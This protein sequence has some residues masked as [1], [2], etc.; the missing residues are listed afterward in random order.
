M[1][2]SRGPARHRRG[3]LAR[4]LRLVVVAGIAAL[5]LAAPVPGAAAPAAPPA[6]DPL[7]LTSQ[8][9]WIGPGQTFD[10]QL[11]TGTGAPPVADRGLAVA[12]YPC[13]HTRSDFDETVTATSLP[14]SPEAETSAP[15]RWTSLPVTGTQGADLRVAVTVDGPS[16]GTAPPPPGTSFAA[17]LSCHVADGG[18]FPV[19]IS[20][21]DLRSGSDVGGFVTHLVYLSSPGSQPLRT[22]VVLPVA[23]TV[24]AAPTV[25]GPRAIEPSAALGRVPSAALDGLETS[26]ADVTASSVPLTLDVSPQTV[27]ALAGS[28]RQRAVTT[29]AQ[30]SSDP[31]VEMPAPGYVPV[32][33]ASLVRAG[34]GS[35]LTVQVQ[36]GTQ[37]LRSAGFHVA[38]PG[39]GSA[40]TWIGSGTMDTPALDALA[41]L[42]YRTIVVPEGDLRPATSAGG[43]STSPPVTV[44]TGHGTVTLLGASADL[45]QRFTGRDPVLAAHQLLAELTQ[46]YLEAPNLVRSRSVVAMPPV[47]WAPEP[48]FVQTLLAGLL[49]NPAVAAVTV[50]GAE[51]AVPAVPG[52]VTG[53]QP[54]PVPGPAIAAARSR[55]DSFAAA[56]PATAAAPDGK[57]LVAQLRQLRLAGE[58]A[59]L[60]PGE[61]SAVLRAADRALTAQI[62]Q[63][64]VALGQSIT[65]TARKGRI[66]VTLV[67]DAGYPVT[68]TLSLTSDK[69]LFSSGTTRLSLR[70]VTLNRANNVVY[71]SVEARASGEF[72]VGVVFTAPAGR[73][74]LASGT[75]VVRS[76]ATSYVGI[77]LSLGAIAVLLGW[78]FRTA[79]RSRGGDGDPEPSPAP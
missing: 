1:A 30:L 28:G 4:T 16:V 27:Q 76:T 10:V 31:N 58:A 8:S 40:A 60:R 64:G 66:P 18:V 61:Q 62:D 6:H 59:A 20:L 75:V 36:Q 45:T 51:R 23:T 2:T 46:I 48:A 43:G 57:P 21:V 9:T 32:D 78:W 12:V 22:A 49:H 65:L 77:V 29:L 42:G 25:T 5:P 73:L 11:A 39:P 13:L 7:V 3:A 33:A 47:G 79:R 71:V 63:M 15:L 54:P 41:A 35:E 68:G 72:R 70:G 14:G 37:V 50:T 24:T 44:G 56:V 26:V 67:N 52:S 74:T 53:G 38:Q 55:L 17:G 19:R 69:L 34:V